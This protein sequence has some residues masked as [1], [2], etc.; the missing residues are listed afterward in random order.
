MA[1]RSDEPA[2]LLHLSP[3]VLARL[4]HHLAEADLAALAATCRTLLLRVQSLLHDRLAAGRPDGDV[5]LSLR[6]AC[7]GSINNGSSRTPEWVVRRQT[8]PAA[9]H[10][11]IAAAARSCVDAALRLLDGA[12]AFVACGVLNMDEFPRLAFRYP[13]DDD[14]PFTVR[15]PHDLFLDSANDTLQWYRERNW[16]YNRC[17]YRRQRDGDRTLSEP[18][19]MGW[20]R[21]KE[22]I[23]FAPYMAYPLPAA[24]AKNMIAFS[25]KAPFGRGSRLVMDETVRRTWQISPEKISFMEPDHWSGCLRAIV[26]QASLSMGFDA[27]ATEAR[28]FKL[29][30]YSKGCHFGSH[31]D[32][33]KEDGMFASLLVFLPTYFEAS[34]FLFPLF[35]REILHTCLIAGSDEVCVFPFPLFFSFFFFLREESSL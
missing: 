25:T 19:P 1:A 9:P 24:V 3:R 15:L 8:R 12:N 32:V 26:K 7:R 21:S 18:E 13:D 33:E 31:H 5:F 23:Q 4:S 2:T 27:A 16:D 28:F 22:W 10:E 29:L 30:F 11:R 17:W 20:L 6:K 14:D 34:Q 35:V